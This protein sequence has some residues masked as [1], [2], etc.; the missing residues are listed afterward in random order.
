MKRRL[1]LSGKDGLGRFLAVTSFLA[2]AAPVWMGWSSYRSIHRIEAQ[3]RRAARM[4]ELKGAIVHME[5]VL[6][7]SARMAAATGDPQWER[8]YRMF[9][10]KLEAAIREAMELVPAAD[11]REVA[12]KTDAANIELVGME[13]QALELVRQG[14]PDEATAILFGDEYARHK[15]AYAEGM[16]EF[17]TVIDERINNALAENRHDAISHALVNGAIIALLAFIWVVFLRA[18]RRWRA[19]L[20]ENEGRLIRQSKDLGELNRSLDARVAQRTTA[21]AQ[22]AE[23]LE[24][25]RA[26]SLNLIDD[27]QRARVAADA[28]NTAK[29]EFLANMSHEIRTPMNG[30]IGMT[31]LLEDTELDGD[32]RMH[33]ETIHTCGESLLE[34]INDIL[35]F[36]KMEAG[37]LDM[38]TIDFDLRLTVEETADMLAAKAD[39]K[40]LEFSCF[41][42]PAVPALLRGAPGRLRQVLVNLT[43]NAIKFT[44]HGEVNIRATLGDETDTHVMVRFAVD[45]TGIG[46]PEG[47]LGV[48]FQA[49][50]Q[51]D[52][53]TTRKYGGT[54]LGLAI[55]QRIVQLMGGEIGVDSQEDTGS[56]FWFTVRLEK[57]P[58]AQQ[59]APRRLEDIE[60]MRA[61]IVDDNRTNRHI[62]WRYLTSWRCQ[63]E[64]TS[65]AAQALETL[66]AAADQGKPFDLVMVDFQMPEMDG[67]S[68]G[69]RIKADPKLRDVALVMLTS[70]GH[71]GDAQ[72][73]QD[74]GFAAY[75]LKPI[76]QSLLFD[77]LRS[78]ANVADGD[79]H[80]P[81]PIVTRYSVAEDHKRRARILLAEDN[82]INQI[83]ALGLLE[84]LGY[85]A[86]VVAN[87]KEVLEALQRT[88]YALVLMDC[89][90]PEMDGYDAT[91]AIR[92]ESVPVRDPHVAIVA[93]TANAMKGDRD[94]CLAVGM[95]DYIAKPVRPEDL[96]DVIERVLWGE[97][98]EHL[99]ACD[100]AAT[101]DE[102]HAVEG[103]ARR[104]NSHAKPFDLVRAL[105]NVGGDTDLLAELMDLFV[106]GMPER[107]DAAWAA[108]EGGDSDAVARTAHTLKGSVG[109]FA[110]KEAFDLALTLET[111]G[112]SGELDGVDG[113]FEKLTEEVHR[114]A[115]AFADYVRQ[116]SSSVS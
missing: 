37:K 115:E 87:G 69:R 111:A 101:T 14:R 107:L 38:E 45:D 106:Q 16:I 81:M 79:A 6:T 82:P 57:Q 99:P 59:S 55:S 41:I 24:Q 51:A 4:A 85:P 97:R 5:E 23:E 95:D 40:G 91:R 32:Q 100:E 31:A 13:N 93:M 29:S 65:S 18:A 21:L 90:M 67:E 15:Q 47:R 94:A 20:A 22:R 49:F 19:S 73:L 1:L 11:S 27:L 98:Q 70:A 17:S 108:I 25:T 76:K 28:A 48:L 61:L 33:V 102:A 68:L 58:A 86:D 72:R 62:L 54:G 64:E 2:V 10:P 105:Q 104:D 44:E 109:N 66:R 80:T 26:A 42:D 116:D 110:A 12:A 77:C 83:V 7:M 8:R 96:A 53:S 113:V 56:T 75:L 84:K 30:I 50:S 3:H 34:L 74:A 112:R 43:N 52:A 46:I 71:R 78:V 92:N 36:S 35:D 63:A 114:L 39:K 89:Q 88:D 103:S 60:G 9:E